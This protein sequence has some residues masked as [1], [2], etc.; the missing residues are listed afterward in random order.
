M[1]DRAA[2]GEPAAAS[3]QGS[4]YGSS[5][6]SAP[7]TFGQLYTDAGPVESGRLGYLG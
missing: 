4:G 1:S 6:L 5:H 2:A 3:F 7:I